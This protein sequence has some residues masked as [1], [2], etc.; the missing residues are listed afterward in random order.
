MYKVMSLD[1]IRNELFM[2]AQTNNGR[3]VKKTLKEA[4]KLFVPM[5]KIAVYDMIGQLALNNPDLLKEC[6]NDLQRP[7]NKNFFIHEMFEMDRYILEKYCLY[8]GEFIVDQGW[9]TLNQKKTYTTGRMY[10]T[11]FRVIVCGVEVEMQSSGRGLLGI[12]VAGVINAINKSII[13]TIKQQLRQQFSGGVR[14]DY[15]NYIPIY[16][17][18][19][20]K[21]KEKSIKWKVNIQYDK[22]GKMKSHTVDVTI[23][24]TREKKQPK[25]EF[26]VKRA[27]LLN[28]IYTALTNPSSLTVKTPAPPIDNQ[29]PTYQPQATPTPDPQPAYQPQ[30]TPTPDPQPAYQPQAT[31][32]P[33]PQPAY[34]PQATPT[35]DP[36][37]AYQPQATPTPDPQPAYQP[38]AVTT[39]KS[40][41]ASPNQLPFVTDPTKNPFSQP[42]KQQ[43]IFLTE[44]IPAPDGVDPNSSDA[45]NAFIKPQ[46]NLGQKRNVDDETRNATKSNDITSFCPYCGRQLKLGFKF[47]N[48][49][50][51]RVSS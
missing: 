50:G 10:I 39:P 21:T 13:T 35:P 38:Q 25:E 18:Y 5:E 6:F 48:F 3:K 32:T 30:A 27:Q 37:P 8:P 22:N 34:Q 20:I 31:P 19:D 12:V 1:S 36:Q 28:V 7:I 9:G 51:K 43:S 33:D 40:Q 26:K 14:G 29:Q 2:H 17:A 16:G 47:C 23:N 49:C 15:G 24:P 42:T 45:L 46:N 44:N 41:P 11:Q 4:F